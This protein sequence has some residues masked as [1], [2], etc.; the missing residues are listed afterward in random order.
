MLILHECSG[1]RYVWDLLL[2][3]GISQSSFGHKFADDTQLHQSS[4]PSDFH[5]LIIDDEQ[6]AD[7]VGR[8]MTGNRL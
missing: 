1:P 6:R 2:S 3:E 5:S 8:W 7:D 4:T